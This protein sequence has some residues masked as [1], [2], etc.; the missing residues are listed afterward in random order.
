MPSGRRVIAGSPSRKLLAIG[1]A[2]AVGRYLQAPAQYAAF[3][4]FLTARAKRNS[5]RRDFGHVDIAEEDVRATPAH[6]LSRAFFFSAGRALSL[7]LNRHSRAPPAHIGILP[8]HFIF[9]PLF[10]AAQRSIVVAIGDSRVLA[11]RFREKQ[12]LYGERRFN[13]L[14]RVL[15]AGGSPHFYFGA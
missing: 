8:A 12:Q 3:I 4:A 13:S 5:R 15:L 11:R 10:F 9:S 2:K 7:M 1:S 14:S 6:S